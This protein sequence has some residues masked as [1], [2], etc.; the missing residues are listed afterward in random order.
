MAGDTALVP[1]SP[2]PPADPAAASSRLISVFLEGRSPRT[3]DAYRRDLADFRVFMGTETADEAARQLLTAGH[4]P[5]NETALRYRASLLG[6]GLSPAT[7][8]RRLAAVRS[9]VKLARLI[10]LVPWTL[11]VPGVQAEKY[12][13]TRGPGR[14][15]V[16]RLLETLDR[17]ATPK[18]RR[19]TAVVRLLYD[20]A[21][22]RGEVVG[23]DI[24]DVDLE[25]GSVLVIG[26][27][28]T[29]KTRLTLPSPT[30][31]ALRAWL[32]ARGA[33]SGPLF[34]N[35][36]RAQKGRR[37]TGRSVARIV[38]AVGHQAGL[39]APVRPHGRSVTPPSPTP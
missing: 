2:A 4:G 6:R 19:D 32:L 38:Q 29:E 9:L 27:G 16:V 7:V 24:E 11:E 30:T 5:A 25:D 17:Q 1:I 20:L 23:L 8:N 35:F 3:L 22:R 21:L 39:T 12:R 14:A 26:K 34:I 28:R 10:G 31:A 33:T 36:D 18:A 37:L 13:D 15:G